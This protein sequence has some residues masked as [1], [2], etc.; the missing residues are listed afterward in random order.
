MPADATW[1][2][3]VTV[4]CNQPAFYTPTPP[5]SLTHAYGGQQVA[6]GVADGRRFVGLGRALGCRR[7][8]C[9]GWRWR[10]SGR[11]RGDQCSGCA[12]RTGEHVGL[13]CASQ[14]TWREHD[15]AHGRHGEERLARHVR[16]WWWRRR[17]IDVIHTVGEKD[18]ASMLASRFILPVTFMDDFGSPVD[19]TCE[20]AEIGAARKYPD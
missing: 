14:V 2:C 9:A 1:T 5:S 16:S 15:G 17:G 20:L 7:L 6:A 11:R 4:R 13:A 10:R 3:H 12:G 8:R 19:L 18:M